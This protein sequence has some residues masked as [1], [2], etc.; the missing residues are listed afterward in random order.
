LSTYR[1]EVSGKRALSAELELSLVAAWRSGDQRAG[2]QIV[3]ACLPFVMTIAHEYRRWGV[4]MED[5]I[6]EG[7]IGLLKAATRFD[8]CRGCRL[9]TY[10][11]YWIRA[12][13]RDYVVRVYR[14]VRLGASKGERRALRIYRRTRERDP[15]ALAEASGLSQARVEQLLPLLVARDSAL[16]MPEATGLSLSERLPNGEPTPEDVVADKDEGDKLEH[17]LL[18]AI[19]ELPPREQHIL[20]ARWLT[21]DPQTLEQVGVHFGISKE[22]VRQ[23]EERAKARLS[24]RIQSMVAAPLAAA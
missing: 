12:E 20:R 10:A 13:I 2:H 3:E 23:L 8:P 24:V 11:A 6:Q 21:E 14:V 7:N 22:R 16:D 5:I 15:Q 1:A 17:A 19:E 18:R 4:P 9:V